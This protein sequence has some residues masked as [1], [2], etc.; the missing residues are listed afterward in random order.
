MDL[1][2]LVFI[3][4]SGLSVLVTGLKRLREAGGDLAL[5]SPNP[6]AMKVFEITGL[7][8]V[9]AIGHEAG[10]DNNDSESDGVRNGDPLTA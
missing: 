1:G 4:S 3:D 10:S 9:F 2:E 7:T 5:R 8:S 6:A